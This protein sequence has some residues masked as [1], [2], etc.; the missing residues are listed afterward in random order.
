M[1]AAQLLLEA[2]GQ[3]QAGR[4]QERQNERTFEQQKELDRLQNEA[5]M[6]QLLATL[7]GQADVAAMQAGARAEIEKN[8]LIQ[9]AFDNLIKSAVTGGE[10]TAGALQNIAVLGQRGLGR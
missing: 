8:K 5:A 6:Q 7:Q 3:S 10:N 9:A 2:Y 4:E 1:A